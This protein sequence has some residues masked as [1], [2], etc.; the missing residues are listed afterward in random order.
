MICMHGKMSM[1]PDNLSSVILEG[2]LSF[3]KNLYLFLVPGTKDTL[4][5]ERKNNWKCFL[6]LNLSPA[7]FGLSQLKISITERNV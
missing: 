5:D 1:L 7:F 2:D 4:E 3:K 6:I